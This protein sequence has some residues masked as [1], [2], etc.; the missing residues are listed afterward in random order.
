MK[1]LVAED[2][3]TSRLLLQNLLA[4]YGRVHNVCNGAQAVEAFRKAHRE[5]QPFDLICLDI[6]MPEMDGQAT[7][8]LIRQIEESAGL[9]IGRGVKILMATALR[10]AKNVFSAFGELC[11]GYLVKPISKT[12]LHALLIEFGFI[13]KEGTV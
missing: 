3:L 10:D 12:K 13:P 5:G 7:L 6:M 4:P 8:K 1:A 2:D 9:P 11:D